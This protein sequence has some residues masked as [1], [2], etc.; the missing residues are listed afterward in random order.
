MSDVN[1]ALQLLKQHASDVSKDEISGIV[2]LHCSS[3]RDRSSL[4]SPHLISPHLN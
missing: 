2:V 3:P 4:I 1:T